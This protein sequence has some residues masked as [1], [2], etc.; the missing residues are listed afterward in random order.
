[1]IRCAVCGHSWIESRALQVVEP[2]IDAGP[3]SAG[4]LDGDP[5]AERE[6][7]RLA[8]A[9][10]A[11]E[12]KLEAN[13]Q[14]RRKELKGWGLLAGAVAASILA[15]ALAPSE[16]AFY[17]PPAR[18]IYSELGIEINVAGL[19]FRNVGQQHSMVDGVR[20]LAIQGEIVNVGKRERKIPPLA[21]FLK[22]DRQKPVYDWRLT[23]AARPVRPG[24][25]SA[26]VTRIA[27]PPEAA[28]HIE[29]RFARTDETGSNDGHEG[30][31]D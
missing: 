22:D 23:S 14:R 17:F 25:V 30:S 7:A 11:A 5:F 29:I 26:F 16:L 28:R 15:G 9:A 12:A 13:R 18:A 2:V 21:F 19:E 20:V 27:S 4:A 8:Q 3:A 31:A 1:M 24:E 10:R 6:V